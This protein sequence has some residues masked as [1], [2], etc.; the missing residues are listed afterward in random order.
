MGNDYDSVVSNLRKVSQGIDAKKNVLS[1]K[2]ENIR[3]MKTKL[4][5]L[6]SSIRQDEQEMEKEIKDIVRKNQD[7]ERKVEVLNYMK[8]SKAES[9]HDLFSK[10]NVDLQ[11]LNVERNQLDV[12]RAKIEKKAAVVN[13]LRK[14]KVESIDGLEKAVR[15][16][17]E[18]VG[19]KQVD[20]KK[21]LVELATQ[22]EKS[23]NIY[24]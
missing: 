3:L 22:L 21:R 2:L 15:S 23:K 10:F 11:S 18:R 12:E 14:R 8:D 5:Q 20:L 17:A 24:S 13:E 19:S 7:L 9:T 16:G 6:E 1:K 4:Y